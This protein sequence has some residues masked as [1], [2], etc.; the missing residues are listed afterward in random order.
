MGRFLAKNRGLIAVSRFFLL[1]L[2]LIFTNVCI[3]EH[4]VVDRIVMKINETAFTQRELENYLLVKAVRR[5]QKQLIATQENWEASVQLFKNDM[6]IYEE[7]RKLRY[8]VEI[9]TTL[10]SDVKAVQ[11]VIETNPE[12]KNLEDRLLLNERD[13][14]NVLR[15]MLRIEKFKVDQRDNA[16]EVIAVPQ[17]KRVPFLEK[18]NYIRMYDDAMSYRRIQPN[19]FPFSK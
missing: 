17:K 14:D 16:A 6:L 11:Q 19:A 7:S 9:P 13:I 15:M 5:S 12:M 1:A 8:P 2:L 10:P 3:A 18:R 4:I